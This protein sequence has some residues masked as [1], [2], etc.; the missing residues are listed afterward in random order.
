MG[1]EEITITGTTADRYSDILTPEAIAFVVA[2]D[3]EFGARRVQLLDRRRRRRATRTTELDFLESTK[4]IRIDE[5]WTVAPPAEDLLDRRVEIT[6]PPERKMTINA[7]NSGARVWMAD[8]EDATAP[9]WENVVI[10][11]L[12]LRDALDGD[13]DFTSPEGKEYKVNG[14]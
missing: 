7:L 9:T 4:Q 8:F 12:N 14:W 11:Q 3:R 10:G 1:A 6:G 13:L 5:T 2:L